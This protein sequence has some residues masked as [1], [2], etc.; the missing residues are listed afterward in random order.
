V[1]FVRGGVGEK[2]GSWET[3]EGG[4]EGGNGWL[5]ERGYGGRKIKEKMGENEKGSQHHL[6]PWIVGKERKQC[7]GGESSKWI[8][9]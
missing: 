1:R 9:F 5:E 6:L 7:G 4:Q 8:C 2:R 3:V